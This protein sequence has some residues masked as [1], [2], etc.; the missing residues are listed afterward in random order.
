MA[1]GADMSVAADSDFTDVPH[2]LALPALHLRMVQFTPPA[3]DIA[4]RALPSTNGLG[5]LR[6]ESLQSAWAE[7]HSL[8]HHAKLPPCTPCVVAKPSA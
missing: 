1:V 3:I 2:G 4:R 6:R 5:R 8:L 7:R